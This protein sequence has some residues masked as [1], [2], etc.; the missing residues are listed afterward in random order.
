MKDKPLAGKGVVVTRPAHQAQRLARL[1]EAAGGRALLFPAIEIRDVEDPGALHAVIDRLEAFDIVI[2]VSPNAAHKAMELIAARRALPPGILVAA[3]GGGSRR[4]LARYAVTDVIVPEGG[5]DSEA[6]LAHPALQEVAGRR[7]LI[8]RG[9]GG[10][11]LLGETLAAR[12]A[13]VEYAECYRRVRPQLDAAPLLAAWRRGELHA[14]T[15]SSSEGLRNFHEMIGEA[16]RERLRATP[17]FV[18][19]P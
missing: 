8:F 12:G 6:L 13:H 2:F 11:E 10:R 1:I 18:T 5:F 15:A 9:V 16:G 3:I 17:L 4:A 7:V 19:H 14:V